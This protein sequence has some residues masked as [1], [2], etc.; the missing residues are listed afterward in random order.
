VFASFW[1][2]SCQFNNLQFGI[3][4]PLICYS[5]QPWLENNQNIVLEKC[6]VLHKQ[7]CTDDHQHLHSVS[8]DMDASTGVQG[9]N[10]LF[11]VGNY[12]DHLQ[13]VTST[14]VK[15]VYYPVNF[16]SAMPSTKNGYAH[17]LRRM[18]TSFLTHLY[19]KSLQHVAY[20][21]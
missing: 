13:D 2:L 6:Q 20:P 3:I 8:K 12:A 15:L 14:Q 21:G 17:M 16:T 7:K 1:L 4:I 5:C 18:S 10:I 11:H 9:G 19:T